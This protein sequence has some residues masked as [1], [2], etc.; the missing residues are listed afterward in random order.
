MITEPRYHIYVNKVCVKCNLDESEFK[1]EYSH[2]K[3]FLE[4]TNLD[5][6]A[7]VEYVRCE[8][9]SLSLFEGSY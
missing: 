2:I 5:K 9:P 1:K 6:A 8:P 3:G 7:N 4:L